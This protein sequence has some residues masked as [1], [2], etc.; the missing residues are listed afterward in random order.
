MK[1]QTTCISIRSLAVLMALRTLE[2]MAGQAILKIMPWSS[3]SVV[4]VRGG[5]NQWLTTWLAEAQS[6]MLVNF[7]MEVLDACHNAGLE[8]VATMCDMGA[9]NVK[10][11]KLLGVSEK[12]PFFRFQDQEIAAIFDPPHLLKCTQNLFLKHNVANVECE[13]TVNGE[14]L[15]GTAKWDDSEVV[16]SWET[17]YRLLP[18]VTERHMKPSGQDT[19]KV[20]LHKLW[21]TLA[22]AI[23]T[24]VTVGKDNWT[25]FELHVGLSVMMLCGATIRVLIFFY[26]TLL[27]YI[28][29]QFHCITDDIHVATYCVIRTQRTRISGRNSNSTKNSGG[30]PEDGREKRPKHVGV[31][32]L[33]TRF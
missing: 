5:S 29:Q 17:M 18:K 10:A 14:W 11:L 24:L 21:A 33:R 7:L 25:E 28:I 9:N 32:Y 1:C 20:W 8:V 16:W 30:P 23:N 22:G 26:G 13:I 4:Y 3:C 15:T 2:A 6:E 27:I 19:M 12:T 31:L